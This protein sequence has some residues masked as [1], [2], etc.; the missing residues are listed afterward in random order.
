MKRVGFRLSAS[1]F[2]E[3][4]AWMRVSVLAPE[5]GSS[6]AVDLRQ[7]IGD[8]PFEVALAD[9]PGRRP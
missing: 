7:C 9:Q 5:H 8:A 2:S 3:T 4:L 6:D 1:A